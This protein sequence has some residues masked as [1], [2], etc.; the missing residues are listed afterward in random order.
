MGQTEM[1]S[2]FSF[3]SHMYSTIFS[4]LFI[5]YIVCTWAGKHLKNSDE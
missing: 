1:T 4:S 2:P 3:N 5:F